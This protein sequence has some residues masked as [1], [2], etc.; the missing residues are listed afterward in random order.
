[1]IKRK[2]KLWKIGLM[3]LLCIL[4]CGSLLGGSRQASAATIGQTDLNALTRGKTVFNMSNPGDWWIAD[5]NKFEVV[6]LNAKSSVGEGGLAVRVKR[7]Q[8]VKKEGKKEKAKPFTYANNYA[9]ITYRNAL[10]VASQSYDVKFTFYGLTVDATINALD[11]GKTYGH[12]NKGVDGEGTHGLANYGAITA[13]YNG[14]KRLWASAFDCHSWT[15]GSTRYYYM[16]AHGGE[17]REI[18]VKQSV[19][20][21]LFKSGT[22]GKQRPGSTPEA[23]WVVNDIDIGN[24]RKYPGPASKKRGYG[25][26][27]CESVT[28]GANVA[29]AYAHT[30]T[31]LNTKGGRFYVNNDKGRNTSSIIQTRA[32]GQIQAGQTSATLAWTGS[33]ASTEMDTVYMNINMT[34]PSPTITKSAN[35]PYLGKVGDEA[36]FT[37]TVTLPRA[38]DFNPYRKITV[39]D[40]LDSILDPNTVNFAST[41]SGYTHSRSGNKLTWTRG[42]DNATPWLDGQTATFTFT[43]KTKV[44]DYSSRNFIVHDGKAYAEIPNSASVN[45]RGYSKDN[46]R[47]ASSNV[48]KEYVPTDSIKL[49]KTV[50]PNI[51]ENAK[52]GDKFEYAYT[53]ENTGYAKLKNVHIS[54]DKIT[55]GENTLSEKTDGI[56]YDWAN[57]T[58]PSTPEGVLSPGEKVTAKSSL[59]L[60]PENLCTI[61]KTFGNK[62][63]TIINTATVEGTNDKVDAKVTDKASASAEIQKVRMRLAKIMITKRNARTKKNVT[64]N[65]A[66]FKIKSQDGTYVTT[67]DGQNEFVTNSKEDLFSDDNQY[68]NKDDN[69]GTVLVPE[70]LEAGT[71]TVIE[72]KAPDGFALD[73]KATTVKI[74]YDDW[75]KTINVNMDNNPITQDLKIQKRIT[76]TEDDKEIRNFKGNTFSVYA[77]EDILDPT[78]GTK[79]YS[80]DEKVAD[81]IISDEEG[82]AVYNRNGE[83]LPIGK[84]HFEETKAA[85][86]LIRNKGKIEFEVEPTSAPYVRKTIVNRPTRTEI[87]K[88]DELNNPVK[89]AKLQILDNSKIIDEWTT[90]DSGKHTISGL[91]L[92]HKYILHEAQAPEFYDK[93][94][95]V[96]FTTSNNSSPINVRMTDTP[97]SRTLTVGKRIRAKDV[98]FPHGNPTFIIRVDGKD[99]RGKSVTRFACIRF[100][101]KDISRAIADGNEYVT[102]T[103]DIDGLR[104][105]TYTASEIDVSRYQ[106]EKIALAENGTV[107]Q[108]SVDFDLKKH[109]SGKVI[110]QNVCTRYDK[111][112]HNDLKVNEFRK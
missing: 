62:I 32:V 85:E 84:Y 42:S 47:N 79:I 46:Q 30:S 23:S 36:K 103:V 105:G 37:V 35:T 34:P 5:K 80:K 77:D 1:M 24:S 21:E 19:K 87:I 83:G 6:K 45:V 28:Y 76:R 12:Y 66:V 72:T 94:D 86:G 38:S 41:Q 20:Y 65:G 57:S 64:L 74:D 93:S 102:K 99:F 110:F 3:M 17:I 92:N 55:A 4:T 104:A 48:V 88:T 108:K 40:T 107:S 70:K 96:A 73:S 9:S 44:Q 7:S 60:T 111:V 98:Y 82:T 15:K 49:T 13:Y 71:Y 27:W 101:E 52:P 63:A 61:G 59:V 81:N 26:E 68:K 8:L 75:E 50:S 18:G 100:D 14:G 97:S 78:D 39:S 89:G 69:L 54:A 90:D 29:K 22:D 33:G 2:K 10:S 43:A 16:N 53:I 109:T 95:D 31:Y 112:S 56:S 91:A 11:T 58:D 67:D 51:I 25:E 106:F